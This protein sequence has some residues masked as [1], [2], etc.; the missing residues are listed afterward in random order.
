[1]DDSDIDRTWQPKTSQNVGE[2]DFSD[3]DEDFD[4]STALGTVC[5]NEMDNIPIVPNQIEIPI[6]SSPEH[7]MDQSFVQNVVE[8]NFGWS[9]KSFTGTPLPA[10]NT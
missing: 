7:S 5:I 2:S 9:Q 4:Q 10:H 1:V 3:S 8:L 6:S